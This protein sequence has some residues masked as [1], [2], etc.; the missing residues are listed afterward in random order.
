MASY[1]SDSDDE[2]PV[3]V[4]QPV[5]SAVVPNQPSPNQVT[6]SPATPTET[7]PIKST[8]PPPK[9]TADKAPLRQKPTYRPPQRRLTLLQK[10]LASQ[11]RHERNVILQCVHF[12]VENDFFG[13]S[14][15]KSDVRG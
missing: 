6:S 14:E 7:T 12:V 15:A 4:Q 2:T 5:P 10:L 11:V 13:E 9:P 3:E 1:N 8:Q